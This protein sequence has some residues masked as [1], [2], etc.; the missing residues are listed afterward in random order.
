MGLS[1][2]SFD[3]AARE[4]VEAIAMERGF[5]PAALLAVAWVE[6]AG[7]P[8]WRVDGEQLPPIRFEGHYFHRILKSKANRK[9]HLLE[10]AVAAGLA[11]PE[12]GAVKNPSSYRARYELLA[13]AMEI[14]TDAALRSI[15]MGL[16]QVMGDHC[17]KLGFRS[18]EAMWQTARS[19]LD[20]QLWLM[21]RYIETFGLS[22]ALRRQDWRDFA[23][24]YNGPNYA[25]GGYHTK[26]A[27]AY[28]SFSR[29]TDEHDL[30]RDLQ[31][32]LT[33]AGYPVAVDGIVGRKTEA[34]IRRFQEDH[35]LVADGIAGPMTRDALE[36][37]IAAKT[38]ERRKKQAA[39]V[40]GG[41][42]AVGMSTGDVVSAVRQ[43]SDVAQMAR[44]LTEAVGISG[45]VAGIAVS[46]VVGVVVWRIVATRRNAEGSA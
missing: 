44:S 27:R 20:G 8:F 3:A 46:L 42:V 30:A 12:A 34:A 35:G 11:H 15:S 14:D 40:A 24:G 23:R 7:V 2:S 22:R 26:L 31:K 18:V 5:E 36:K 33:A 32:S 29:Q 21:V 41:A 37:A 4:A 43:G 16:G 39:G 38:A 45:L 17:L 13:R 19:G 10:R 25:A 6:S 9:P 28:R 1:T